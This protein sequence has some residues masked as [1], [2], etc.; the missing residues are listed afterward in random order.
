MKGTA[1][2]PLRLRFS[3]HGKVRFVSHRDIARAALD[4]RQAVPAGAVS[5]FAPTH[6]GT[7]LRKIDLGPAGARRHFP[8]PGPR[9][10]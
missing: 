1:G 5:A 3:E 8:P 9:R 4:G 10:D 7:L 2:H 6:I